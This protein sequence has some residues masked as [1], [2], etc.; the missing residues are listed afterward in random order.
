VLLLALHAIIL[1]LI[2]LAQLEYVRVQAIK[3]LMAINAKIATSLARLAPYQIVTLPANHV[4][5][6]QLMFLPQMEYV[7]VQIVFLSAAISAF[8]ATQHV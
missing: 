1:Q 6:Q 8:H 2:I 7:L 4:I 3:L 5:F